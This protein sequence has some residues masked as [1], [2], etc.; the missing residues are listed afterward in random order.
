MLYC[1]L[2]ALDLSTLLRSASAFLASTKHRRIEEM[3]T[4]YIDSG[5]STRGSPVC[6]FVYQILIGVNANQAVRHQRSKSCNHLSEFLSF[7]Y[8]LFAFAD[9]LERP[10]RRRNVPRMAALA[11]QPLA[12]A[13]MDGW[14]SLKLHGWQRPTH[15][16]CSPG[17]SLWEFSFF[18]KALGTRID[19]TRVR[20]ALA[21]TRLVSSKARGGKLDGRK[22]ILQGRDKGTE[23]RQAAIHQ[24]K[25]QHA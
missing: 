15:P 12:S 1:N 23:A 5:K 22:V 17:F 25:S 16:S 7:W 21:Q 13:S 10:A 14:I 9:F 2:S 20:R 19:I 6:L 11:I 8:R 3:R 4:P 18:E 24:T